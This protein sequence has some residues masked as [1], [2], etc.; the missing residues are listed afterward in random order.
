MNL[1]CDIYKCLINKDHGE[2]EFA[3]SP[4]RVRGGSTV[5]QSSTSA[6]WV[7]KPQVL[8]SLRPTS[9]KVCRWDDRDRD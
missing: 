1:K 2:V 6:H 4:S 9:N 8:I 7:T 5:L 3:I